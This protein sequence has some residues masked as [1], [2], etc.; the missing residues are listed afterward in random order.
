MLQHH[1]KAIVC[2]WATHLYFVPYDGSL[3][4]LLAVMAL[5]KGKDASVTGSAC[6][7]TRGH[8]RSHQGLPLPC[9][10]ACSR[11]VLNRPRPASLLSCKP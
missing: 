10:G 6:A 3:Q 9:S 2:Q 5:L 11:R 8:H 1:A 4:M 7:P